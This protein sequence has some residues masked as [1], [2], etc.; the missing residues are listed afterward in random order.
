MRT[1]GRHSGCQPWAR[2]APS[3]E[4]DF[5]TCNTW[6]RK[7]TYVDAA[8]KR[9]W[10]KDI[11]RSSRPAGESPRGLAGTLVTPGQVPGPYLGL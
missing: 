5:F 4:L 8:L 9:K 6:R 2:H 1:R 3:L 11:K 10:D 7:S